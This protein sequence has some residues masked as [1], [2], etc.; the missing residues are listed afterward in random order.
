MAL[1]LSYNVRNVRVRWQVTLLA[2]LGIALVVAVFAVLMSMSEG[3][4]HALRST[5]PHRQRD[6][7]PARL[8]LR[9]HL[10]VPLDQRQPDRRRTTRVARGADGQ[11][12]A[13]P[14]DGG[15]SPTS[16]RRTASPT[17]VT[18]RGVTPARVRGARR[19]RDRRRAATSRPAS[20][21]SSSAT[22]I[23]RPHPAASTSARRVKLQ[24]QASG[25]SW[26]SSPRSGGAF[27]SEI[28]GDFD[29]DR[30]RPSSA[31]GMQR[32]GGAPRRTPPTCRRSTAGSAPTRRCSC[33]PCRSASTTTT[34]P[35]RWPRCCCRAW[36]A[37][38]AVHH[39]HRRRLRRHEHDVRASWPR[40]PARSAPCARSAS[41]AAR[42]SSRSCW[43]RC[44]WRSSA[45]RS[46]AC[47]RC[48]MNGYSTR[49]RPDPE[50]QRDRVRLPDHARA[51]S[52]S[53]LVFAAV[54]GLIGGLLPA[55]RG[56][57]LPITSALR[58]A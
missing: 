12:L 15:R 10:G 32:A 41:R 23:A 16:P 55:V 58:E 36:P 25:R 33:R 3:F 40:A 24:Q 35:G 8:G 44:S 18:L 54:M 26:A 49:H 22:Q 4:S 37:C 17:N 57:R 42:S 38:V 51:S 6:H 2:I 30:R 27:E 31:G 53:G 5:G 45:A 43:S 47:S 9:A 20:T 48:P 21:R 56:A 11:P 13:S 28:W 7:R 39:G 52:S 1:P 46:A 29:V 50:L 34:R 19:H 14:R